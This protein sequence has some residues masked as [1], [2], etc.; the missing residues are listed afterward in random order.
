MSLQD[1]T[2]LA[3]YADQNDIMRITGGDDAEA[4]I[5]ID[6]Q[7]MTGQIWVKCDDLPASRA[8]YYN[9]ICHELLHIH[10]D[11]WQ[12]EPGIMNE[13]KEQA[14]NAL[15]KGMVALHA[16]FNSRLDPARSDIQV[17]TILA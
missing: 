6:Q 9:L 15:A 16:Q 7:N 17:V 4:C 3:Q 12:V 1:W 2:I 13:I 5:L 14:I 8:N 10:L 11:R